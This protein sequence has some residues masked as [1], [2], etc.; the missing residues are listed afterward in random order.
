MSMTLVEQELH[1]VEDVGQYMQEIRRFPRL[2]RE[3]ERQAVWALHLKPL[4]MQNLNP[5]PR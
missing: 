1:T 5:G 3:Q 4:P 2:T